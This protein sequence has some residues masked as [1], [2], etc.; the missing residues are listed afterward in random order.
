MGA[1]RVRIGSQDIARRA[2]CC[3]IQKRHHADLTIHVASPL[4]TLP[5]CDSF[6]PS[7][8]TFLQSYA[9]SHGNQMIRGGQWSDELCLRCS[10]QFLVEKGVV[11]V[12]VNDEGVFAPAGVARC[13]CPSLLLLHAEAMNPSF[14]CWHCPHLSMCY[15]PSCA[16]VASLF[17]KAPF[18]PLYPFPLVREASSPRPLLPISPLACKLSHT[19]ACHVT[20]WYLPSYQVGTTFEDD[21]G[22][23]LRKRRCWWKKLYYCSV[24]M[25]HLHRK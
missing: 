21:P 2:L 23:F 9:S 16:A 10:R 3:L 18:Q 5:S 8:E 24:L 19:N 12:K 4:P 7:A 6:P 13:Y 14:D 25:P 1:R 15:Y 20:F 22:W 11:V 17:H